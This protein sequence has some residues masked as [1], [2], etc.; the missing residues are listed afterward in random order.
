MNDYALF[1]FLKV[2]G[3]DRD[4]NDSVRYNVTSMG[5]YT[6]ELPEVDAALTEILHWDYSTLFV[7]DSSDLL[8]V[9]LYNYGLTD[10]TTASIQW[11]FNHVNQNTISWNGHLS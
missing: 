3:V 6:R 7:G 5:C 9:I 10:I 8:Q 2:P 11:T 1:N 4:I